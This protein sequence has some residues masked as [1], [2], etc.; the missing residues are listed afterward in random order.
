MAKRTVR[1]AVFA[2][3]FDP[4]TNGHLYMIRTGAELFDQLILAVGTNPDKVYTFTVEERLA[5]LEAASKGLKNVQ[6]EPMA[7][8]F[9]VDFAHSMGASWVLRG[10]RDDEDYRFE[11]LM[12]H[13]NSDIREAVTS[14]FLMPPRELAEVSSSFVKGLVGPAGWERVVEKYLPKEVIKVLRGKMPGSS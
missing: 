1:K 12:R 8:V 3:S 4:V 5:M 2:G 13:M 14:V 9:L 10:L 7:N 6:V 11:R